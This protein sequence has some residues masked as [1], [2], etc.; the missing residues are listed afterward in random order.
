[1]TSCR[2]RYEVPSAA[3]RRLRC[4]GARE[5]QGAA[6]ERG[7]TRLARP[8]RNGLRSACRTPGIR[9]SATQPGVLPAPA[10]C[11]TSAVFYGAQSNCD[12]LNHARGVNRNQ[13]RR[14]DLPG[15]PHRA[16]NH[17]GPPPMGMK[18]RPVEH[19]IRHLERFARVGAAHREQEVMSVGR[20]VPSLVTDR[21]DAGPSGAAAVGWTAVPGSVL[22][23]LG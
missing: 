3:R 7:R 11:T 15:S 1:M 13:Y 17:A 6:T 20:W 16:S 18:M 12:H 23:S 10:G 14:A 22:T 8:K 21:T 9:G 2:T 5:R 4:L 19:G